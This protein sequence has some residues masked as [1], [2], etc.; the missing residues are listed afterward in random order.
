MKN[1][2]SLIPTRQA[3]ACTSPALAEIKKLHAE[4]LTS[5]DKAIRIGELLTKIKS[6]LQHG[7]WLP[8]V[9]K[10]LPFTDRAAT[11]YM[12]CFENRVL[13]KS[14]NV[15]DLTKA[16]KFLAEPKA[17]QPESPDAPLSPEQEAQLE[18]D[19]AALNRH[20]EEVRDFIVRTGEELL[21][22]EKG[23]NRDEC[24]WAFFFIPVFLSMRHGKIL[25][26]EEVKEAARFANEVRA[27]DESKWP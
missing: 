20:S 23:R 18:Q 22:A 27:K 15:S 17:A 10:N 11:N 19:I 16:Y 4:I 24:W 25:S 9:E 26:L 8:W 2:T 1:N 12:R 6:E 14:E 13:L 7:Q 3:L 21:E 5:L